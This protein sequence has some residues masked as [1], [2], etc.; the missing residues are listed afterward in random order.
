M[1][2][3]FCEFDPVRVASLP[4]IAPALWNGSLRKPRVGDVGSVVEISQA[5]LQLPRFTVECVA[6]DGR[7]VWMAEFDSDHLKLVSRP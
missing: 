5:P 7:T 3:R 4:H 6:A 2:T 1:G